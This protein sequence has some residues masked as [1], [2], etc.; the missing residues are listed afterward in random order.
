MF[1]HRIPLFD[2]RIVFGDVVGPGVIN[3]NARYRYVFDLCEL[4]PNHTLSEEEKNEI[5]DDGLHF[6]PKGYERFGELAGERLVEI[7]G[8]EEGKKEA[9]S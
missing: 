5:W 4:I 9:A 1:P 7:I 2:F 3:A 6:T 8:G